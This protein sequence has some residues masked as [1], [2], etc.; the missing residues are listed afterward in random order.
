M[1][2]LNRFGNH[3]AQKQHEYRVIDISPYTIT[4]YIML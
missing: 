1:G 3:D 4:I 2:R